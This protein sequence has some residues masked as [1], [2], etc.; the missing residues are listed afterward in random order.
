MS[1]GGELVVCLR[2]FVASRL[3]VPI[4]QAVVN[5]IFHLQDFKNDSEM[6]ARIIIIPWRENPEGSRVKT[7][8]G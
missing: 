5:E 6:P 2:L 7:K 8:S 4:Q 3:Q 1:G